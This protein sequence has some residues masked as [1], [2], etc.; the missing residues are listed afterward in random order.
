VRVD[1]E[2][3][4]IAYFKLSPLM[5]REIIDILGYFIEAYDNE[6]IGDR[7]FDVADLIMLLVRPAGFP[8]ARSGQAHFATREFLTEGRKVSERNGAPS[9]IRTCDLRI[10]RQKNIKKISKQK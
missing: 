7:C 6:R 5:E 9:R 8:S 10:R 2:L 1:I 3:S 4:Y